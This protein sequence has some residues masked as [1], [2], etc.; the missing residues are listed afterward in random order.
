MALHLL[1]LCVGAVSAEDLAAH[2]DRRL[3]LSGAP[4][5][6]HVTRMVPKRA[7]ELSSGGS[8]YW[9]IRGSVQARQQILGIEP[10]TDEEGIGRCKILLD[11]NL[12]LTRHQPKRP[13]QGWRYLKGEDAPADLRA[14]DEAGDGLPPELASALQELGVI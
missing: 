13:F 3:A 1:K 11:R 10:F 14:F 5:Y 2:I 9:I 8:L 6:W 7:E 4:T 12:V